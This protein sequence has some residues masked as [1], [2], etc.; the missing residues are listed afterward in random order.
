MAKAEVFELTGAQKKNLLKLKQITDKQTLLDVE[1]KKVVEPLLKYIHSVGLEKATLVAGEVTG[2]Y[3]ASSKKNILKNLL[4][5]Y[6]DEKII[7][8][9]TKTG[10]T[11]EYVSLGEKEE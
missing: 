9:C 1:K 7:E 3:K 10:K 11:Y 5:D 8:K 4:L 2:K 6:L